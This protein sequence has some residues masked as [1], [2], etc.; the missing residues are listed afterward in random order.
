MSAQAERFYLRLRY[1]IAAGFI[2]VAVTPLILLHEHAARVYRASWLERTQAELKRLARDRAELIDRHLAEQRTLLLTLLSLAPAT[3]YAEAPRLDALYDRLRASGRVSD[4]SVIDRQGRHLGYRGPYAAAL[5]GRNYAAE[6]WFVA[7]LRAGWHV[8]DVFTGFRG[9]PHIVVAVA[10]ASGV[11][12]VTLDSSDFN[13]LVAST[14]V[15]PGGDAFLVNRAGALQTPSRLGRTAMRAAEL[16]R[17]AAVAT[18]A[19]TGHGQDGHLHAAAALNGGQWLLVLE[20][21]VRASLA[22]YEQARRRDALWLAG[23]VAVIVAVAIVLT[24]ALVGRLLSAERARAAMAEQVRTVE[25]LAQVGQLA[26]SVAHEVNNPLQIIADQAGLIEDV[27]AE[28]TDGSQTAALREAVGRIRAQVRRTA[29]ITRRLLGFARPMPPSVVPTALA[30]AVTETLELLAPEAARR[31]VR[32]ERADDPTLPPIPLDP[33]QLQ[34]VLLNLLHNALDAVGTGGRVWVKT[35][36]EGQTAVLEVADDGPGLAPEVLSHLFEPFF[37]TKPKGKGTGLGLY[38]VHDL[39]A[40]AGGRITAAN[41]PEGG[42]CF[43]VHLP[44]PTPGAGGT[45]PTPIC[46][47]RGTQ[48]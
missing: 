6:P 38:V 47:V 20:T 8:S 15:G 37:S 26:A 4:V 33:L 48:P 3:A 45:P 25:Q 10:D 41:R 34:Q 28:A 7:T 14:E 16:E 40:R 31:G 35:R 39:V 29:G 12:R 9:V 18:D 21:D 24:Q 32:I 36:R 46:S 43:T 13:R 44:L 42:A 1:L 2:A 27:L 22:A 19:A 11:L 5:A 30:A 23:A 17:F